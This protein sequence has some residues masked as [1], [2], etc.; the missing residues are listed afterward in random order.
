MT[1]PEGCS[2]IYIHYQWYIYDVIAKRQQAGK[3]TLAPLV[4]MAFGGPFFHVKLCENDVPGAKFSENEC[5]GHSVTELRR[6]L[7]C[8]G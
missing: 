3:F 2:Q 1:P 4:A 6:W 5:A 7:E 8:R